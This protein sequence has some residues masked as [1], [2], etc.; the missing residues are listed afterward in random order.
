MVNLCKTVINSINQ[1]P[2]CLRDKMPQTALF[3]SH[4]TPVAIAVVLTQSTVA[5]VTTLMVKSS[6]FGN[7]KTRFE[8]HDS[9][10][11]SET[12]RMLQHF[13]NVSCWFYF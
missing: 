13:C 2:D 3:T 5:C 8:P 6:Q 1:I 11:Q 12:G 4:Y 7:A 10:G 9:S